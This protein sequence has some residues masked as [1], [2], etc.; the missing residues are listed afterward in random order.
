L[1]TLAADHLAAA[2]GGYEPQR[3]FNF[4]LYLNGVAGAEQIR[5]STVEAFLPTEENEELMMSFGNER[6]YVAG[7]A[8]YSE[9]TIVVRDFVD[10]DVYTALRNW[11]KSVYDPATGNIGLAANYKKTARL[12]M[13]APDN[14]VQRQFQLTGLWPRKIT[15]DPLTYERSAIFRI[16]MVCRYDKSIAI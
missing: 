10:R 4:F 9:G 5:L 8:V 6:V 14:S 7:A 11:R 3:S 13:L 12:V 1:T 2:G 16:S 15:P